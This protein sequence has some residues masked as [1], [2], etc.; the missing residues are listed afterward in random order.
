MRV[1]QTRMGD[2]ELMSST[3]DP[4]FL[5]AIVLKCA[6]HPERLR[7]VQGALLYAALEGVEFT[8]DEVLS[9]DLTDKD[10]KIAGCAIGA[11][12]SVKLLER[13]DRC[14]SSSP[15]R[16]G[17]WVN[18]WRLATGKYETARTWLARNG[19]EL[20]ANRQLEMLA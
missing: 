10:P 16:N 1:R 14:K 13:T 7:R 15:T 19:F 18:R 6:F 17:A 12:A 3:F 2:T 11:L 5:S 20:P 8:T 4:S 9:D